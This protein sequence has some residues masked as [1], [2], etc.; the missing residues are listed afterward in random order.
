MET[1]DQYQSLIEPSVENFKNFIFRAHAETNHFYDKNLPYSFHLEAVVR[2]GYRYLHLLK[3]YSH[4]RLINV[5]MAC[6]GHDGIE[7]A[8]L[9]YNDVKKQSNTEVA[10]MIRAVTNYSR[11]RDRAERMPDYIYAEIANTLDSDYVK[12]C[13]RIANVKFSIFQESS[14]TEK[15]RK[16]LFDFTTKVTNRHTELAPMLKKLSDLLSTF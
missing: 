10:G 16:E 11:G 4:E 15:Y 6:Y 9:S 2:E 7:D 1:L 5:I 8:R 13:D 12:I 14:M 3:G